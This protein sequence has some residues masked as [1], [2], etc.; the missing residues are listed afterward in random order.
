[1]RTI[2]WNNPEEVKDF[3][4]RILTENAMLHM[5]LDQMEKSKDFWYT[6][7]SKL[8]KEQEDDEEDDEKCVI[9]SRVKEG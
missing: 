3:V 8:Q 5:E 6:A 4:F 1:M 9:F 7:Y 2:D